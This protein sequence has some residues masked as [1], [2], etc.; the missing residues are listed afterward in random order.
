M[1]GRFDDRLGRDLAHIADRAVPSPDAWDRLRLRLEQ[2][3]SR[4]DGQA[5]VDSPATAVTAV[6]TVT[7]HA[8][9]PRR[10][11]LL[12]WVAGAAAGVAALVG[13]GTLAIGGV[14][15]STDV[16]IPP[17]ALQVLTSEEARAV[18][19]FVVA[20]NE[21]RP[22]RAVAV[23]GPGARFG[24]TLLNTT[25]AVVPIEGNERP[26]G[27][28]LRFLTDRGVELT[29]T[30]CVPAGLDPAQCRGRYADEVVTSVDGYVSGSAQG[31]T[32]RLDIAADGQGLSLLE[33]VPT[34][35]RGVVGGHQNGLCRQPCKPTPWVT[36]SGYLALLDWLD[37]THPEDRAALMDDTPAYPD[38]A[39]DGMVRGA[40]PDMSH[41]TAELWDT[42]VA[43]WLDDGDRG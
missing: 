22:E 39:G 43:E 30:E 5:R 21:G 34:L 1:S 23:F 36:S 38:P 7:D 26:I 35:P 27:D 9:P 19:E 42:R 18:E 13:V 4:P 6:P 17:S 37:A 25:D 20:V 15:S 24:S 32:L 16:G 31:F 41:D 3:D 8:A 10:H 29:I 2:P 40:F 14:D 11:G 33:L 28:L 12:R